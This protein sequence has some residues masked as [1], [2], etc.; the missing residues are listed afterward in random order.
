MVPAPNVQ[1]F[2]RELL[3]VSRLRESARLR[4][5]TDLSSPERFDAHLP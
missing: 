1:R 3:N 4:A 5:E 2:W